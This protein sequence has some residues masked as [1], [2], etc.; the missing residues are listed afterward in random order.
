MIITLD[1]DPS[2]EKETMG[3]FR[4]PGHMDMRTL[5]PPWKDN[6]HNISCVPKGTY[7]CIPHTGTKYKDVYTLKNVPDRDSILIHYGN[8]HFDTQGCILLGLRAGKING[9]NA[10][11][12]SRKA[13][14]IL[15]GIVGKTP[16]TLVIK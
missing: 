1:R 16:F 8:T 13:I 14:D 2:G 3:V 11:L 7:T 6:K 4:I 5:E 9:D 10:V 15:R 12:E